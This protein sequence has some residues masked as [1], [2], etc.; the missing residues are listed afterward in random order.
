MRI[1]RID[2]NADVGELPEGDAGIPNLTGRV[3]VLLQTAQ[4]PADGN[5]GKK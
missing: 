3:R 2:L 4:N 5:G 1:L